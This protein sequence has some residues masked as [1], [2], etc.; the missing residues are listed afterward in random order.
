[1]TSANNNVVPMY[2]VEFSAT[3]T[4]V[5][6]QKKFI[7]QKKKQKIVHKSKI[8]QVVFKS[9][10]LLLFGFY[11]ISTFVGHLTSNSVYIYIHIQPKIS[12]RIL[13]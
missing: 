8:R 1:M 3:N 2:R 10:S 11:G 4:I 5:I 12:K 7:Y 6:F 13:R 9:S